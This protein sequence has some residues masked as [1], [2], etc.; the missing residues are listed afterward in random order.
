MPILSN[1][2]RP[3]LDYTLFLNFD[4]NPGL[5][6]LKFILIKNFHVKRR[7]FNTTEV[8]FMQYQTNTLLAS[9]YKVALQS[10]L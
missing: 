6:S 9:V 2:K 1:I 4:L 5:C 3:A 8:L 7:I 10:D